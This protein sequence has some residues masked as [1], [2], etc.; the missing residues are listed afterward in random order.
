MGRWIAQ[1]ENAI[2]FGC[3]HRPIFRI[4]DDGC[5]RNVSGSRRFVTRIEYELRNRIGREG[6]RLFRDRHGS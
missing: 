5:R 2:A 1:F 3:N 6:F 4:A